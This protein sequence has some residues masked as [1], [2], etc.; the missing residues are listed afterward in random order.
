MGDIATYKINDDGS[1]TVSEQLSEHEQ[2]MIEILRIEKSKGGVFA[3]RRMKKRAI[4]Y[5]KSINYPDFKVDKLM[6][7]NY[8]DDFVNYPRTTSLLVW[9]SIAFVFLCGIII[10]LCPAYYEYERSNYFSE[11]IHAIEELQRLGHNEEYDTPFELQNVDNSILEESSQKLLRDCRSG[12]D[13]RIKEMVWWLLG[14]L[15]CAAFLCLS[16]HQYIRIVR[17]IN[18]QNITNK[19]Q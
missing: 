8:P 14:G 19:F 16:L 11:K 13:Y 6:L 9:A 3:S 7:D 1:V 10:L 4:K 18:N 2:N 5:A 12:R 17:K 15:A